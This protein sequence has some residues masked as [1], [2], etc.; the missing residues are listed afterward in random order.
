VACVLNQPFVLAED[1]CHHTTGQIAFR[2]CAECGPGTNFFHEQKT[3]NRLLAVGCLLVF[4]AL[5]AFFYIE[6]ESVFPTEKTEIP[7]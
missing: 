7:A 2:D 6:W 5:G 3:R 4:L 1:S